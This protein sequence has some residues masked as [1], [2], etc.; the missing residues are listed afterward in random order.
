MQFV[1]AALILAGPLIL[2][3][4]S[5]GADVSTLVLGTA[6]PGGG[7]TV[8]GEA[9][10]ET[11]RETGASIDIRLRPTAGSKENI[12][13]LEAGQLDLGLVEGTAAYEALTGI[14]R[15]PAPLT[16]VAAMYPSPGMFAVRA[17]S[18]YRTVAELTGQRVVF[19]AAGSGLVLLARYVLDGLGLDMEKDFSA[20]LLEK[21]KDAPPMVL[22]GEAAA[23]WGGGIGW[24]GFEA[25]ARG[26]NG[27]RFI[28][29]EAG[30]IS[31]I[32]TKYP[33]L[34]T[35]TVAAG[36]YPGLDRAIITVGS[37]GLILARPGLPD[38]LAYRFARA[39]HRAQPVLG[40]RLAQAQE[41]T[42]ANTLAASFR[43]KFLHPG[44]GRYL[45]ELGLTP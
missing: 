25:I 6:T 5:D 7:F 38:D 4:V 14:G 23:L 12:P 34:N 27:A 37:W 10:A 30:D 2:T 33:F 22:S 28:G 40:Q 24:P 42:P 21:V 8:Y 26:P 20:V 3:P 1:R 45:R 9:L 15:S 19:G 29:L 31:R 41:T 39:L 32:Q 44:V 43:V 11:L 18:P 16:V 35:M 36:T 17:D 13:L